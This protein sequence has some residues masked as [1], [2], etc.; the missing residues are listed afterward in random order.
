MIESA[1]Y[2]TPHWVLLFSDRVYQVF[3]SSNKWCTRH[4]TCQTQCTHYTLGPGLP[5]P[6][7]ENKDE[8]SLSIK[9]HPP[10]VCPSANPVISFPRVG[11][12]YLD[13]NSF[14]NF[15]VILPFVLLVTLCYCNSLT[16]REF[17]ANSLKTR[18]ILSVDAL[19]FFFF[20][21]FLEE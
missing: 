9:V 20:F 18:G 1:K 5:L 11:N 14:F 15:F 10:R 12:F 6:L 4:V 16:S 17:F 19:L 3:W 2:N 7:P 8:Y 13:L 21:F